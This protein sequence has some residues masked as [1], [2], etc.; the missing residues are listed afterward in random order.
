MSIRPATKK[1]IPSIL[2]ILTTAFWD[3]DAVGRFMHPH[4]DKY[5]NDVS[6]Y[7][8]GVVRESWWRGN[9]HWQ[10]VVVDGEGVVVGFA[11]WVFVDG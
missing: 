7:W 5:P 11:G 8:R 2:H 3:E 10:I 9:H 6:K 4:R 1:D